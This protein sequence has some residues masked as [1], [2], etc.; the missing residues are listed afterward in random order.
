M[1]KT[2]QTVTR[3]L[4]QRGWNQISSLAGRLGDRWVSLSRHTRHA[5]GEWVCVIA[6][7][8]SFFGPTESAAIDQAADWV[9]KNLN[10][11]EKPHA[12]ASLKRNP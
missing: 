11:Q 4:D 7:A 8:L 1:K 6:S 9:Q 2:R 10:Q 12:R 5:D 3:P